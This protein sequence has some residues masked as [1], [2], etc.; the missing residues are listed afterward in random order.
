M[1][2]FNPLVTNDFETETIIEK[3]KERPATKYNEH[4]EAS[5]ICPIRYIS[6]ITSG[7]DVFYFMNL[8]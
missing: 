8:I 7:R 6:G 5:V 1:R 4:T 3:I 2:I